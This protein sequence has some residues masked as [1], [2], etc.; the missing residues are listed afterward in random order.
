MSR[1]FGLTTAAIAVIAA[2]VAYAQKDVASC[3]PMLDAFAKV[4][5]TP[6][7]MSGTTTRP[8][9]GGKSEPS[10]LISAGGQHYVLSGGHWVRSPMTPAQMAAQEQDNI[11]SAKAFSCRRLR[12][13]SVGTIAAVVYATHSE[14]DGTKSDGQVWIAMGS[15]L[16]LRME[17]DMDPGDVDQIHISTRYDYANVHPPAGVQ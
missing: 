15:G 1:Q 14:N 9:T 16:I 6:Y 13:E 7:H 11:R 17:A 2:H 8:R 10:E 3:K 12:D 4:A 5:V